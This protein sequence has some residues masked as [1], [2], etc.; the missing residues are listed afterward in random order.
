MDK[1]DIPQLVP[2]GTPVVGSDG[3]VVGRVVATELGGLL[4][5]ENDLAG[6][7][8][9]V[10]VPREVVAGVGEDVVVLAATHDEVAALEQERSELIAKL[11]AAHLTPDRARLLRALLN[12]MH[13][14]SDDIV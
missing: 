6:D 8:S 1:P 11:Q 9:F 2:N 12:M 10:H 13:S 5:E 4:V 7:A 3:E 14:P